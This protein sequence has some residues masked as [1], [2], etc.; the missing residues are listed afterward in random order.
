[1]NGVLVRAIVILVGTTIGAGI[2]GLPYAVA[3]AGLWPGMV[4]LL[5]LGGVVL[6][7][8][9]IYGEVILHTKGDH[10]LTGY[11]EIY[12]G[13]KGKLVATLSLLIGLYGA[14]LA[15]T[16]KIG[17]FLAFLTGI[18]SPL[19]LSLL[20]F[21]L[22]FMAIALGLRTISYLEFVLV[23]LIIGFITLLA[24][25]GLSHISPINYSLLAISHS[26]LF[27][28]YGVILFALTGAASIPEMEE[29]LRQTGERKKLKMAIFYGSLIP[30]VT[31]LIFTLIIVG[32]SGSQTSDDAISGL[33]SF[34]PNWVIHLG[35]G[36]GILTMGTSFLTLGYVLR[37]VWYRDYHL[38]KPVA[39]FLAALPP[40][41]LF[42]F[43]HQSFIDVLEITGALTG[44][45][46]GI[47]IILLYRKIRLASAKASVSQDKPAYH[48]KIPTAILCLLAIIFL[49]GMLSPW[50]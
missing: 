34:L 36:L 8:N 20:F 32:I 6:L 2:F 5:G 26:S 24:L 25:A 40:L 18:H 4:Y 35:A 30:L 22:A 44:G 27:L 31:Y 37:E 29:V 9:L 11:G 19:A 49:L 13:Q 50:L 15:Y 43:G 48:L 16:I 17:E 1:M 28:P 23:S 42:L 45:L 14:L 38:S 41:L 7:L 12:F 46:T 21:F 39:L 33:I 3:Q 47:L 10:Q